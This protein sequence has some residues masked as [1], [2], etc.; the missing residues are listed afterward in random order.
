MNFTP[1]QITKAKAAKSVEELL[2]LAKENGMELT[3]E[4][5]KNYFEQWH[6]EGELADDELDNVSGGC[7][8]E[9]AP[10][11]PKYHSGQRIREVSRSSAAVHG[12]VYATIISDGDVGD[13]ERCGNYY[14]RIRYDNGQEVTYRESLIDEDFEV[15]G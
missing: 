4:E 3:E 7:G 11:A 12:Y 5:A 9:E 1:E 2:A 14:Y 8:G 10:P 15:C 6:K 13:Y